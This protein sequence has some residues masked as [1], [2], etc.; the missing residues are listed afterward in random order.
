MVAYGT[1]V[2]GLL[3]LLKYFDA[4]NVT[5]PDDPST[6]YCLNCQH[7]TTGQQCNQCVPNYFRLKDRPLTEPCQPYVYCLLQ[8]LLLVL[9]LFYSL[10][11]S[12]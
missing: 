6:A 11:E 12:V 10:K 2:V 9:L 5:G 7:N 3:Q 1:V 8:I 4:N